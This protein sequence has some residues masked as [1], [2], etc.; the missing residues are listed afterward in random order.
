M[1]FNLARTMMIQTAKFKEKIVECEI[2]NIKTMEKD[3]YGL[4]CHPIFL[5][6]STT[7]FRRDMKRYIIIV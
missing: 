3:G 1:H 5:P 7:R 2:N 6:V 4:L